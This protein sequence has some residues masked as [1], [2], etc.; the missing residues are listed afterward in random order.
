MPNETTRRN[1]RSGMWCMMV[2]GW[3]AALS[4]GT[5]QSAFPDATALPPLMGMVAGFCLSAPL[6]KVFRE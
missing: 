2:A 1:L 5:A 4:A 6:W 3:G